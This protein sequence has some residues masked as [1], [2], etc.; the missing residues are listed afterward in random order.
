MALSFS[1]RL[2]FFFT[3]L[4]ILLPLSSIAQPHSNVTLGS[5]LI[6]DDTNSSWISP[7][8]EFAFGFRRIAP[9]GG[10][11]L[12]IW[13]DK[14]PDKTMVWSANRD[15]PSE[16]GSRIQL[17][18]DG[19][20]QLVNGPRLGNVIW[21]AAVAAGRVAY[22]AMLDTGNFV[23]ALN[24]SAVAWQSFDHPTDTL[25]P[26]QILDQG[27]SLRSSYSE[28]NSSTGKFDCTVGDDGKLV[29]RIRNFPVI[30]MDTNVFTYWSTRNTD[31]GNRLIFNQSGYIFLAASNGSMLEFLSN[32]GASTD[33]L[34]QRAILEYDG[35]FRHY[36]YPKSADSAGGRAMEWSF[37]ENFSPRNMCML[38]VG[39]SVQVACGLNSFCSVGSEGR[40]ICSCPA[41][42]SP[43]DSNIRMS[44]CKPDFVSQSCDRR[45]QE[46]E[47]FMFDEMLNTDFVGGDYTGYRS[48]D[49]DPCRRACLDD[50]FCAAVVYESRN[51]W[52]KRFP[53]ANGR[54]SSGFN[55]KALIK[56]RK[57]NTTVVTSSSDSITNET[58][59]SSL[60]IILSVLF[61]VSMFSFLVT[62]ILLAFHLKGRRSKKIGSYSNLPGVYLRSFSFNELQEAT[63]GFEEELGRGACSTVYKGILKDENDRVIAVKKLN[64]IAAEAEKEFE[65]EVS[66]ISRTNHKN[67]VKLLGYCVEGQN[68]LLV[69]EFMTDGSLASF[70]FG[71]PRPSWYRRVQI[72]LATARG[73][74]YLH[75]ECSTQIIH[76]DI[77]PQNI[78]LDE[79]LTAKI[80]DFGLAKLLRTDQ[81]K[82]ITA[83]RGTRGYV[84]PEWYRNMPVTSKVDVY[85]FGILLLELV[86]CRKKVESRVE[87][88][89]EVILVDWAYDCYEA[90][91]LE[92]LVENDEEAMDDIKRFKKFVMIGIW[93]IQEDPSL[94]PNM[95][96]V[97]HMLE[98]ALEVPNPPHPESFID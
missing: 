35:V 14:I 76:C 88:E 37:T 42:Y 96:R 57:D 50:C 45:S 40:P 25:L 18:P 92:L 94:R 52:K 61:G 46:S 26:T 60:I 36:V 79:S 73:L 93:C 78:L 56:I 80:S 83:V 13:F 68:R 89:S 17:F 27:N 28:T 6:A 29:L 38:L 8:G 19:R 95:K 55:G 86:C 10:Y 12:A 85:S 1:S 70:L 24:T 53:L 31:P 59:R 4:M 48:M 30:P 49:E 41:G 64:K 84:A 34:Y 32:N 20:F 63:N 23:L 75:E 2:L 66:S 21:N 54:V 65:A 15:S 3:T 98:G 81:T 74:C 9:D 72:A 22:G 82:T 39:R 47:S 7:S 33:R 90:G 77:K 44:G 43:M 97:L 51:C 11:L 16:E 5:F 87:E 91:T 69:Y 67:L 71:K 58:S 62:S